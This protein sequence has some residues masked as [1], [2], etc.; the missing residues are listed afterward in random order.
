MFE[1]LLIL[2]M[3]KAYII[4]AR[5]GQNYK[6]LTMDKI[7]NLVHSWPNTQNLNTSS[8]ACHHTSGA[9]FTGRSSVQLVFFHCDRHMGPQP[10]V[11]AMLPS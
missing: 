9:H 2:A 5:Y 8:L 11:Q 7:P 6:Q 1:F 10:Q 3:L 4:L